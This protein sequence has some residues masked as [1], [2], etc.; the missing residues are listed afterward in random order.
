MPAAALARDV[1][2]H[3]V[4]WGARTASRHP[5]IQ[6]TRNGYGLARTDTVNGQLW[7]QGPVGFTWGKHFFSVTFVNVGPDGFEFIGFCDDRLATVS[8]DCPG[9]VEK[10]DRNRITWRTQSSGACYCLGVP[11]ATHAEF[12]F[13]TAPL[14]SSSYSAAPRNKRSCVVGCLL[15]LDA[16]PAR[17][18]VFVDGE[19]LAVQCEYAFPTDGRAWYPSVSLLEVNSALHSNSF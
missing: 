13:G 10:D 12:W 15:N 7:A 18:T 8:H 11:H 1:V 2:R 6:V 9:W 14:S 19:P 3:D 17:M 4:N 5:R 16:T